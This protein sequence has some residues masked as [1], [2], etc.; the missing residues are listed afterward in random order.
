M[1]HRTQILI[2]KGPRGCSYAILSIQCTRLCLAPARLIFLSYFIYFCMRGDRSRM[3][4]TCGKTWL[5]YGTGG[6]VGVFFGNSRS[7]ITTLT[8]PNL[9]TPPTHPRV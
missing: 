5:G 6:R 3:G 4:E 1:P 9:P 2:Y 7:K 8:P